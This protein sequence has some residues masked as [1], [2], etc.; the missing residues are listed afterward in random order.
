ML[1]LQCVTPKIRRDVA[2]FRGMTIRAVA[3]NG[4]PTRGTRRVKGHEGKRLTLLQTTRRLEYALNDDV[5]LRLE[6]RFSCGLQGSKYALG[7]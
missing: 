4:I 3:E 5:T 1:A 6:Y 7:G 2:V